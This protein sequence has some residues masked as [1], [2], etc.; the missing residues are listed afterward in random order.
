[1]PHDTGERVTPVLD[2]PSR[3]GRVTALRVD[4]E[5]GG[6]TEG[7]HRHPPGAYVYVIEGSVEFGID[8]GEPEPTLCMP[9]GA[10]TV[11]EPPP[12]DVTRVL[13]GPMSTSNVRPCQCRP[14]SLTPPESCGGSI[15]SRRTRSLRHRNPVRP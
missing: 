15:G 7:T 4:Y 2:Y 11:N 9:S 13:V 14:E 6:F 3:A 12:R 10:S 1:M 8:N 5:P